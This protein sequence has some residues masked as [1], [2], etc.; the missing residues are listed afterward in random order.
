MISPNFKVREFEVTD[1]NTWPI[2][3]EYPSDKGGQTEQ[4]IIKRGAPNPCTAKVTFY[5]DKA[6]EFKLRYVYNIWIFFFFL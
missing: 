5:K 4:L 6:F 3:I 1:I 2:T